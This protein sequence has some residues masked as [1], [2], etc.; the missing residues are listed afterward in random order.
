ML[1]ILLC[2]V[3]AATYTLTPYNVRLF[4]S[5]LPL[6]IALSLAASPGLSPSYQMYFVGNDPYLCALPEHEP[7]VQQ[8]SGEPEA[9][10]LDSAVELIQSSFSSDSCVWAYDLRRSYWTYAFCNA[11]KI[12]QYHEA[13]PPAERGKTHLAQHPDHVFV[14]GRFQ[15]HSA[16]EVLFENQ[17]LPSLYQHYA[18][19]EARRTATL[20]DE[21]SSP[22]V[23]SSAQKVVL[24][25]VTDGSVCDMTGQPRTIEVVYKCDSSL[26]LLNPIIVD[27]L[28]IKVCHYKMLIHIPKL[29]SHESFMPDKY[30]QDHLVDVNCQRV[31]MNKLASTTFV[32]F[33]QFI[34]RTVL[35]DH[36]AFP[37]RADNRINIADHHLAPL[38]RGFY[39]ARSKTELTSES[40]YFNHRNVVLFNGHFDSLLDLNKQFAESI[41]NSI[42]TKLLAPV[43]LRNDA[44]EADFNSVLEWLHTFTLFFEI[45]DY[46]G[47][48]V[49]I[50]KISHDASRGERTVFA[51][52][53]DPKTL[54]DN[55][56]DVMELVSFSRPDFDAPMQ[57]WNFQ[58]FDEQGKPLKQWSGPT[59]SRLF[60]VYNRGWEG[61]R[62]K[63]EV[64]DEKSDSVML[65]DYSADDEYTFKYEVPGNTLE[66]QI[67]PIEA[68]Q[69]F[70][71]FRLDVP[72][73]ETSTEG[74]QN[75]KN[76]PH[77]PQDRLNN[78]LRK[79]VEESMNTEPRGADDLAGVQEEEQQEGGSEK[80]NHAEGGDFEE[81]RDPNGEK[82]EEEQKQSDKQKHH[83]HVIDEL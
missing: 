79:I 1:G 59:E 48:L 11:D 30:V 19:S 8:P 36:P 83:T 12:I 41:I 10:V 13:A 44:G 22:F 57:M 2:A 16:K 80:A 51:T 43:I 60:V 17:A 47:E 14:L 49:G 54:L 52:I 53:L 32:L 21:Q 24:Q 56:G 40:E 29:C 27:V 71:G 74:D 42:G 3:V 64:V 37:V 66:Y 20:K 75:P 15:K 34:N 69:E 50:S 35:R 78:V 5:F 7:L 6:N 31:D 38:N 55:E 25:I 65:G 61:N 45:Y 73:V 58:V 46:K 63:M 76:L 81:E 4:E 9:E 67:R 82:L 26:V 72:I 28:E 23:H 77:D 39:V 70:Y 33:D 68:H 62:I 18:A